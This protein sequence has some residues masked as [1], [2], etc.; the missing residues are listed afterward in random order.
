MRSFSR[1]LMVEKGFCEKRSD[2]ANSQKQPECQI[3]GLL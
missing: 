3:N 1:I 2:E